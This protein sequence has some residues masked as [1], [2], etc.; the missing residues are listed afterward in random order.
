MLS[1]DERSSFIGVGP[2][3]SLDGHYALANSAWAI[4]YLGGAAA[5]I[6]QR[7]M[8]IT[9][10]ASCTSSGAVCTSTST[11]FGGTIANGVFSTQVSN[12]TPVLNLDASVAL[13]YAFNPWSAV[14]FGFR[15]DG[16]WNALKTFNS[17]G[18]LVNAD[19]L[20]YGPFL[21]LTGHF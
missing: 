11:L 12:Y 15:F 7:S 5:L 16:Y 19:R 4:E 8:S 6:G 1:A 13:A 9:G 2:R 18:N 3:V 17:T 10:T 14:S 21:R 20:Y